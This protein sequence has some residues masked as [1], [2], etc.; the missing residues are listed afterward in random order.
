MFRS[1]RVKLIFLYVY[2]LSPLLSFNIFLKYPDDF[3]HSNVVLSVTTNL[4]KISA[5]YCAF[6][7]SFEGI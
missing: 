4:V 2:F 3:L 5:L 7:D 1:L 6:S